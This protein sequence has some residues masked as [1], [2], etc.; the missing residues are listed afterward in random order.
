[1]LTWRCERPRSRILRFCTSQCVQKRLKREAS[2]FSR[3]AEDCVPFPLRI[4]VHEKTE[5]PPITTVSEKQRDR[6]PICPVAFRSLCQPLARPRSRLEDHD[7]CADPVHRMTNPDVERNDGFSACW[8]SRNLADA[9]FW[10]S[11]SGTCWMDS[12]HE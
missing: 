6:I 10:W 5:T 9:E 11:K 7:S 3:A 2:P 4:K 12:T 8:L 1:M